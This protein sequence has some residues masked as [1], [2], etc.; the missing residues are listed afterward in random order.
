MP[1]Y[2]IEK[3][4]RGGFVMAQVMPDGSCGVPHFEASVV[5]ASAWLAQEFGFLVKVY[6]EHGPAEVVQVRTPCLSFVNLAEQA[7]PLWKGT[8]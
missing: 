3:T 2:V 6:L 8:Q 4:D 1:R 7:E 5:L